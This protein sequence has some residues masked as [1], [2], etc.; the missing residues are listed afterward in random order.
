MTQKA[1]CAFS[2]P[3]GL[4]A[5]QPRLVCTRFAEGMEVASPSL[6]PFLPATRRGL[7]KLPERADSG[8]EKAP[9]TKV[10]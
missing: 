4:L 3:S 10:A 8:A 9:R 5:L 2:R 6:S 7:G 1:E